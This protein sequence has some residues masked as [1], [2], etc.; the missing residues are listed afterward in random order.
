VPSVLKLLYLYPYTAKRWLLNA[1]T[2]SSGVSRIKI[3]RAVDC[4]YI[5][6][7]T[8][9]VYLD[10]FSI[11]LRGQ[12][13]VRNVSCYLLAEISDNLTASLNFLA[14]CR[15]SKFTAVFR[16]IPS[17]FSLPEPRNS[18]PR[19]IIQFLQVHFNNIILPSAR[20]SSIRSLSLR[21]S[22]QNSVCIT[23]LSHACSA[24]DP[25]YPRCFIFQ[26]ICG[27]EMVCLVNVGSSDRYKPCDWTYLVRSQELPV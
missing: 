23:L 17:L 12:I 5:S 18:S 25:S 19:P 20:R 7:R 27:V 15:N 14:F 6:D 26:I 2:C 1:E 3:I 21:V 11:F 13:P 22:E 8:C 4:I 24:P 9:G 16:N 10:L